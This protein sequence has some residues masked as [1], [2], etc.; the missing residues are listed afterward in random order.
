MCVLGCSLHHLPRIPLTPI[1]ANDDLEG[2]FHRKTGTAGYK[3]M[4]MVR[5]EQTLSGR[6]SGLGVGASASI[7]NWA[8][9]PVSSPLTASDRTTYLVTARTFN[10]FP[11]CPHCPAG[12]S[13]R[14]S[15]HNR[16]QS[17]AVTQNTN[18][19]E[20]THDRS[21]CDHSKSL[22]RGTKHWQYRNYHDSSGIRQDQNG[23]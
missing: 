8:D 22:Q 10:V 21:L 4:W 19:P 23:T 11:I 13:T 6:G 1:S 12:P 2:C 14:T 20:L 7:A 17:P 5:Q 3:N 9:W 18:S 15:E 16:G